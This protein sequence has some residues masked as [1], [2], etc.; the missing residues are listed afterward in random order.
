M[1]DEELREKFDKTKLLI[2][3]KR[4]DNCLRED[5]YPSGLIPLGTLEMLI[6]EWKLSCLE[7]QFIQI[8]FTG[9]GD[10]YSRKL[11]ARLYRYETDEEYENRFQKFKIKTL[12]DLEIEEHRRKYKENQEYIEYLRLKSKFEE[13]NGKK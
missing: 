11:E 3:V 12:K 13:L 2:F 1:T 4:M 9:D 8:E 5:N 10:S 7:D 6:H